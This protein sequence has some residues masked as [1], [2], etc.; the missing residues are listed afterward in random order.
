MSLRLVR[1]P[2]APK[3]TSTHG[4]AGWGSA[5]ASSWGCEGAGSDMGSPLA[6]FAVGVRGGGKR[7]G[8]DSA[9]RRPFDVA[10]ELLAHGGEHLLAEGVLLAGA[11]A[12]EERRREHVG[13]HRLLER[14]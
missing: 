2:E 8:R 6:G 5:W 9:A 10:A 7:R 4:G 14:G 3:R 1:S 11:E 13:R 12:R